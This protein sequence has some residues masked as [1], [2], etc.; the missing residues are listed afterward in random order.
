ICGGI[1]FAV[2]MTSDPAKYHSKSNGCSERRTMM[3]RTVILFGLMALCVSPLGAHHGTALPPRD[4][5]KEFAGL[6]IVDACVATDAY[7]V[8]LTVAER[9]SQL[10]KDEDG[11][12]A[13]A[14]DIVAYA[15]NRRTLRPYDGVIT[16]SITSACA[17]ESELTVP[18]ES[19]CGVGIDCTSRFHLQ[20]AAA[21]QAEVAV[22]LDGLP[23]RESARFVIQFGSRATNLML[24]CA[25][26]F[27]VLLSAGLA[28]VVRRGRHRGVGVGGAIV[29]RS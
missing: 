11:V 7:N 25:L 22:L 27:L 17:G 9:S 6:P 10:D 3:V 18:L 16:L 12:R 1:A 24:L 4:Y 28:F 19:R 13:L 23:K 2:V 5:L 15:E 21:F 8:Y 29:A 26:L 14:F 20:A